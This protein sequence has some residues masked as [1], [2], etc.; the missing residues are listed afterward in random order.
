MPEI[1]PKA[2]GRR[3]ARRR[4]EL[5]LSGA[6]LAEKIGMKQQGV[7][8]IEAGSVKRPRM[9]MELA[10]ELKTSEEW[11]L[12]GDDCDRIRKPSGIT[13]EVFERLRRASG[14]MAE[15]F[16][17]PKIAEEWLE[18]LDEVSRKTGIH[19]YLPNSDAPPPEDGA[20]NAPATHL[21][22]TRKR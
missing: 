17:G 19:R 16:A 21:R 11:L 12:Y 1:D 18:L 8:A 10:R 3:V 9:L 15:T 22:K 6:A 13:P 5:G 14:Q 7:S 20:A 4:D 2:F